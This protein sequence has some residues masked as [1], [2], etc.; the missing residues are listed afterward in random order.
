MHHNGSRTAPSPGESKLFP[1]PL[2]LLEGSSGT[3]PNS[4]KDDSTPSLFTADLNE[5]EL[6]SGGRLARRYVPNLVGQSP[7]S[8]KG[9]SRESSRAP[10]PQRPLPTESSTTGPEGYHQLPGGRIVHKTALDNQIHNQGPKSSFQALMSGALS[11]GAAA[12]AS[13]AKLRRSDEESRRTIKSTPV[14]DPNP[15]SSDH[16]RK[17]SEDA[18]TEKGDAKGNGNRASSPEASPAS[19][20]PPEEEK[21]EP[22]IALDKLS[23]PAA[24]TVPSFRDAYSDSIFTAG[25]LVAAVW[26]YQPQTKDEF[27]LERGD[28]IE[29]VSISNDGWATGRFSSDRIDAWE[30]KHGIL[31]DMDLIDLD[32]T[33]ELRRAPTTMVKAFPLVCVCDPRYWRKAVREG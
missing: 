31:I 14:L 20:S 9:P 23:P 18:A 2:A 25:D 19:S 11:V 4:S 30:Q 3:S 6:L 26:S 7:A 29:I 8:S 12:I 10:S 24:P 32:S 21:Q 1:Y 17:L 16:K 22:N 33:S 5:Y 15:P 13:A 28:M 27:A